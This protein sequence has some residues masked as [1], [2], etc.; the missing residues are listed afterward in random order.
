[1]E[2]VQDLGGSQMVLRIQAAELPANDNC[3]DNV[4]AVESIV[5]PQ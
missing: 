2:E 3:P 1:M 5:P 4:G